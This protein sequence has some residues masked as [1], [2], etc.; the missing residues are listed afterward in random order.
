MCAQ[1]YSYSSNGLSNQQAFI[2]QIGHL[3]YCEMTEV[4][5]DELGEKM[6]LFYEVF[7]SVN[8]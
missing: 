8:D 2:G 4:G 6:A 3:N 1:M 5:H 7:D